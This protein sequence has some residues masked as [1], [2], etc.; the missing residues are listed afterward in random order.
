MS[1]IWRFVRS[2]VCVFAIALA[3]PVL[4]SDSLRTQYALLINTKLASIW[5]PKYAFVG[6]SLTVRCNWRWELGTLSVINFAAGG[7]VIGEVARQLA[8]VSRLKL[9]PKF[10]FVEGGINDIF[11][12]ASVD[13]ITQDF[14]FLLRQLPA[15]QK[16]I[17]TLIPFTS[18]HSLTHNIEAANSTIRSQAESRGLS[19]IDLNPLIGAQ[20]IRKPDMTT[21]GVHFTRK[22]CLVWVDEIRQ[23]INSFDAR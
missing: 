17:V 4:F 21:D 10:I 15:N 13:G 14:Q 22:A 23:K 8:E 1:S 16:A 5:P 18:D 3:A 11:L 2:T 19:I 6:D 7:V 9:K 12:G 20:G